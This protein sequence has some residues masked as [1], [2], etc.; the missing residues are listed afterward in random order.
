MYWAYLFCIIKIAS[1]FTQKDSPITLLFS[2]ATSDSDSLWPFKVASS[3]VLLFIAWRG[4]IKFRRAGSSKFN[5]NPRRSDVESVVADDQ[6]L[7]SCQP[8]Y[9]GIT[10]KHHFEMMKIYFSRIWLI[11][12]RV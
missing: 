12:L 11:R 2:S 10:L 3:K 1:R 6:S 9:D 4:M 7:S 8:F 5:E